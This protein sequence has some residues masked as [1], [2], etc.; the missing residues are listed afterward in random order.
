MKLKKIRLLV[1]LLACIAPLAAWSAYEFSYVPAL[2]GRYAVGVGAM[3]YGGTATLKEEKVLLPWTGGVGPR[4]LTY[5][6]SGVL[7]EPQAVA[8]GPL[9]AN[10]DPSKINFNG[11]FVVSPRPGIAWGTT[12]N[13]NV[14]W[15]PGIASFLK[16]YA[17]STGQFYLGLSMD[18]NAAYTNPCCLPWS[19]PVPNVLADVHAVFYNYDF[20]SF[21]VSF[22]VPGSVFVESARVG[23]S[24]QPLSVYRPELRKLVEYTSQVPEP[25]TVLLLPIGL[26]LLTVVRAVTS[27][28]RSDT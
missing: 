10:E 17:P 3:P 6:I 7:S 20:F 19:G 27:N 26:I 4:Y 5:E 18:V 22:S 1:G 28:C 12:L 11:G 23:L 25:A 8:T 13:E 21:P 14:D 16:E 15:T 2:T 24:D 9:E